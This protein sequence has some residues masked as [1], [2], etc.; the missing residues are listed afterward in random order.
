M[1][2]LPEEIR[3][4]ILS[5]MPTKFAV[6]TSILSKSWRYTWTLVT[7]LDFDFVDGDG[8]DYALDLVDYTFVNRVFNSHKASKLNIFRLHFGLNQYPNVSYW[9]DKA[10]KLNV[11]ALDMCVPRDHLPLSIFT[12]TTLTMLRL[13]HVESIWECPSRVTLPC[14]KTLDIVVY[15]NPFLN[16]FK[17]IPGCPVLETLSL[18]VDYVC[19]LQQQQQPPY[20]FSIPTLKRFKL[21]I[22]DKMPVF[23]KVVLRLPILEY[24]CVGGSLSSLYVM[25]DLPPLF[26]ADISS[27]SSSSPRLWLQLLKGI[28]GAK[29]LTTRDVDFLV[30]LPIFPNMKRLEM[31]MFIDVGKIPQFL[32]HFPELKYICLGLKATL[33][34]WM[35]PKVVPGCIRTNLT[36]L[37]YTLCKETMR[38]DM[39]FLRYI[40]GNAEVL[41][42]VTVTCGH[43]FSP[44][45]LS[46]TLLGPE[47]FS[48]EEE[49]W[50]HS[51]LLKFP[52]ASMDCAIKVV[53]LGLLH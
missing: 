12:C 11:C 49:K 52:R 15:R 21:T 24:L 25:E 48:L 53:A 34:D 26:D 23:H 50:L 33:S 37:K 16:A 29:S 51:E 38:Y 22:N 7:N 10:V 4:H 2:S 13:H 44:E 31:K 43:L 46:P 14:L 42:T 30:R 45:L 35:E 20:I 8:D 3:S 5:L 9:V 36:T 32:E 17:L 1:D 19:N 6:Q 28:S 27:L 39:K 41:K 40:L 18:Q 47:L